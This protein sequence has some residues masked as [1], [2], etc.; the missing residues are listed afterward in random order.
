[1]RSAF[2]VDVED[3]YHVS[4]FADNIRSADWDQM[5]SRVERNTHRV[6]GILAR[7][8]VRGTFFVLGW[9]AEK[10]PA[11]VREIAAAGH[12]IASHSHWHRLVYDL[13]PAEFR[14]DLRRS[15]RF[16]EDVT[17]RAI[18]GFR[19]ASFSI[20]ARSLWAIEILA[21]EGFE[22]DSSIFPVHHDRYGMPGAQRSPFPVRT[23]SGTLWEVPPSVFRMAGWNLPMA[24]GGYFRL[25]PRAMFERLARHIVDRDGRP[26]IFYVH[27]WE[28]DVDQPR[29]PGKALSR[30]RHYQN[31]ASTESKLESLLDHFSFGTMHEVVADWR[32]RPAAP[33]TVAE[34]AQA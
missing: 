16:L 13:E 25:Y 23:P 12:E 17:G 32:G 15:K 34:L 19:A 27:P 24:G 14:D 8:G 3:Y 26:L 30:W 10:Y 5:E 9:V 4:G 11:L 18:V 33:V 22:Y 6:L 29:L 2:T 28:V 21:E 1:M 7:H 31:L 20:V